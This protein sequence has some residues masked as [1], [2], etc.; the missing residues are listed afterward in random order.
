MYYNKENW[1]YAIQVCIVPKYANIVGY[2]MFCIDLPF[3]PH[4]DSDAG[5]GAYI[6]RNVGTKWQNESIDFGLFYGHWLLA[7][8]ICHWK[9]TWHTANYY[10]TGVGG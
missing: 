6:S 3:Y 5:I 9:F 7:M 10:A 4:K 2:T 8:N 1:K